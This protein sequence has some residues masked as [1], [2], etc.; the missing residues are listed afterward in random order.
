MLTQSDLDILRRSA[1][2]VRESRNASTAAFYATLFR[3]A[4]ELRSMF[5]QESTDQE[6]KFAATLV[7]AVNS[8]SDWASLKP[9]VEA[10]ARRHV[11]YGVSA[12]HYDLVG[13]VLIETLEHLGADA[14]E[15]KVWRNVYGLLA[16]HMIATAYPA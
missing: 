12:A 10:L 15:L 2:F 13:A 3:K 1:L 5:P 7:V 6:R 8:M 11:G 16:D 4:P 9:V 14:R